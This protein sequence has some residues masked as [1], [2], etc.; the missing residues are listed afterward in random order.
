MGLDINKLKVDLGIT[1]DGINYNEIEEHIKIQDN[2]KENYKKIILS[3]IKNISD[4]VLQN[5]VTDTMS[6]I[7]NSKTTD[8]QESVTIEFTVCDPYLYEFLSL[9]TTEI[10][11]KYICNFSVDLICYRYWIKYLEKE[12]IFKPLQ[13]NRVPDL[14]KRPLT[15]NNKESLEDFTNYF[16][17]QQESYSNNRYYCEREIPFMSIEELNNAIQDRLEEFGLNVLFMKFTEPDDDS[18]QYKLFVTIK[19]PLS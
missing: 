12:N 11:S 14:Y 17:L 5:I 8:E 16:Q 13:E 15:F 1:R 7:I 19:N 10:N 4:D 9:E 6:N 2:K 3:V 18:Y